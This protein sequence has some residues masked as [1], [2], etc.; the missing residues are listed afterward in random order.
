LGDRPFGCGLFVFLT[1]F[2]K[3]GQGADEVSDRVEGFF[4]GGEEGGKS[5]WGGN[6]SRFIFVYTENRARFDRRVTG[7]VMGMSDNFEFSFKAARRITPEEVAAAK[8]AVKQQFGIE[9][10]MGDR[11]PQHP[12]R[13]MP[14][15]ISADFDEP[16]TD[17]G[18]AL[19]T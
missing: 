17:L 18:E 7:R 19:E 2:E 16:M 10:S 15:D 14:I 1:A 3:R 6:G 4:G 11:T 5:F 12:L 13:S 8:Q 9:P